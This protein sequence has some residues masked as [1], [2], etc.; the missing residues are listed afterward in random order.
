[1]A[2]S[3]VVLAALAWMQGRTIAHV[4]L[5][6]GSLG[7]T[8]MRLPRTE[9][10][11]AG[12]QISTEL[13]REARSSLLAEVHPIDDIRSTAAYRSAVAANLLEEFLRSLPAPSET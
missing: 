8:P 6:G 7:E 12:R 4:R 5:A 1:M 11:L 9:G 3:K 2:I 13:L 10:V